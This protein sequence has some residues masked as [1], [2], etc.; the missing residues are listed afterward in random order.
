MTIFARPEE[1]DLVD[2]TSKAIYALRHGR[3]R[4]DKFHEQVKQMYSWTDVAA[5]TERVYDNITR[6]R[7]LS[8]LERLK[9]YYGCGVWAGKLFVIC[10]VVDYLLWVA[11]CF[12]WP[13]RSVDVAK[14]WPR[15]KRPGG[16]DHHGG[17]GAKEKDHGSSSTQQRR[18][19][20]KKR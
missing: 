13:E 6:Q 12:W 8:L 16:L 14:N 17:E 19:R 4:T 2:A 15:K 10:V 7:R 1:D 3:V 9:R 18:D 20:S 11:L 5:R